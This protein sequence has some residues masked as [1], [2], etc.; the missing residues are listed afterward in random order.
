M[1]VE[2]IAAFGKM[3]A[4]MA[5]EALQ[6][7]SVSYEYLLEY[8][9]SKRFFE[10]MRKSITANK[11]GRFIV[12]DISSL[13]VAG[14]ETVVRQDVLR[15]GNMYVA[16]GFRTRGLGRRLLQACKDRALTDKFVQTS[17]FVGSKNYA[18]ITL[19]RNNGYQSPD[20]QVSEPWDLHPGVRGELL[21]KRLVS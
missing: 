10:G 9:S 1:G 19:Y 18:G 12:E 14:V 5:A 2:H 20:T 17:M 21:V 3:L 11:A 8:G 15:I 4:N 13:C 7:F 16:P 6:N